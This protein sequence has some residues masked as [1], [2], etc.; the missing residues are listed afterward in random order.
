MD[1]TYPSSLDSHTDLIHGWTPSLFLL[2]LYSAVSWSWEALS[3]TT[4]IPPSLKSAPDL[5]P[6][7]C[8]AFILPASLF[9]DNRCLLLEISVSDFSL[10]V[11]HQPHRLL[12]PSYFLRT[13]TLTGCLLC[14]GFWAKHIIQAVH[15][16]QTVST[17]VGSN[18]TPHFQGCSM[19]LR[20]AE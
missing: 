9:G 2:V 1:P 3:Y 15:F 4:P 11:S 7:P 20:M 18:T 6:H 16:I 8:K 19:K 13:P 14:A 10:P 17:G 5:S 12:R